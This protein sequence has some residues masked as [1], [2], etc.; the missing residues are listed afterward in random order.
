MGVVVTGV[1]S[2]ESRYQVGEFRCDDQVNRFDSA[3]ML[4]YLAREAT[5]VWLNK[6]VTYGRVLDH[7]WG[8][9]PS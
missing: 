3:K 9:V 4:L 2:W 7:H 5:Y 1:G 6:G 8:Y